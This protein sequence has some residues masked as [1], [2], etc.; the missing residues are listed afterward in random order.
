MTCEG[1]KYFMNT[2][3]R[4]PI[5]IVE[6]RGVR[7]WDLHG[8]EYLDF[9]A[10][11]AVNI[12]GHSHPSIVKA[13][14]DQV[15][16]LMHC[17]NL[18]WN[19]KQMEFAKSLLEISMKDGKV[20]LTNSGTEAN[21]TALKIARK[22]GK[23]RNGR[24]YV[25]LSATESFHGR[26]MGSLSLTGQPKYREKFEPML[27]GVEFVEYN[28]SNELK[29]K[30]NE[31]VCAIILEPIQGESGII[32][33]KHEFLETA[34]KLCDEYDAL[35]IFDEV[36]CG[37]GRTGYFFAFQKY[38]V[39]PD[40]LTVAKG[41]GGGLPIGATVVNERADVL[42]PGDHGSTFGGNPVSCS[43]GIAVMDE[44]RKEG[45]LDHVKEMGNYAMELLETLKMKDKRVKDVRGA[46]L[47]IGIEFDENL[48]AREVADKALK[49]GALFVPAG[50]NTLRLLPPLIVEKKDVEEAVGILEKTL[51]EL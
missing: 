5:T 19:D 42:E 39:K 43:A 51:K 7:V 50:R 16:K 8:R 32:P 24:K 28:D 20:F 41:L 49:N 14:K 9:T 30:M 48:K 2:Y 33:A 27:D 29:K 3:N 13:V 47:M 6:G 15:E 45:F 1:E 23:M 38:D 22:Y 26:T 44:L 25:I 10:G 4:Y 18:F 36:Q 11:I 21:E 40:I 46:G 17:S 34:R 31:N 12:L 37:M 35:L